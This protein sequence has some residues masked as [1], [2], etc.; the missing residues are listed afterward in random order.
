MCA[1]T[2]CCKGL[3]P[4]ETHDVCVVAA[5]SC[6]QA[7]PWGGLSRLAAAVPDP[8]E[9]EATAVYLGPERDEAE[10]DAFRRHQWRG[11]VP[12]PD[13]G[14]AWKLRLVQQAA[15][16]A[17]AAP[18]HVSKSQGGGC[19]CAHHHTLLARCLVAWRSQP[20]KK[21]DSIW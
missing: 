15:E 3:P 21:K 18:T 13:A 8:P 10:S 4:P 5:L 6:P 17:G 16:P 14:R 2:G 9:Q 19:L 11:L 20:L 7:L 1:P 12:P